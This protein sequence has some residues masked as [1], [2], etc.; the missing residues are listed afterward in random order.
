MTTT[1]KYHVLRDCINRA[2]C[3]KR[4]TKKWWGFNEE[5]YSHTKTSRLL[6]H[7]EFQADVN[8]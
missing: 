1:P 3:T 5:I 7:L 4:I 8:K 2:R 6:K